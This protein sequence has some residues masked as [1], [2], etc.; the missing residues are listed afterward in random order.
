MMASTIHLF[1]VDAAI[2]NH[3]LGHDLQVADARFGLRAAVR[4]HQAD[5]D[6]DALLVLHAVGI[7][8]H[9]VGL[10]HARRG[11]EID[12]QLGGFR[13][14]FQNDLSH[15]SA[16]LDG[17]PDFI[18][19]GYRKRE[20]ECGSVAQAAFNGDLA[21]Q[22]LDQTPHQRQAE[23]RA[24]FREGVEAVEDGAQPLGLNAAA[25]VAHRE[26]HKVL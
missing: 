8:E 5:D 4:L 2:G 18:R 7:V 11:A 24:F 20:A 13:L 26:L 23:A 3:A 1:Q 25:G 19:D 21:A 9:V 12:A 10:A 16:H 17:M 22:R 14:L 15:G 6:I